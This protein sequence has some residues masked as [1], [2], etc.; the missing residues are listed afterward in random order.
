[1]TVAC[2]GAIGMAYVAPATV[3]HVP[4]EYPT[5]QA[6][7][8]AAV[9][10]DTVLAADGTYAGDGN[11]DIDFNGKA[12]V[13]MSENGPEVT[14]I[15]CEGDSLDP[16]RGFFFGSGEGSAS[17][18]QGFTIK[19]GWESGGGILCFHTSPTIVGNTLMANVTDFRG[20]GILCH[21]GSPA[22][23]GNVLTGNS[24]MALA[25]RGGGIHCSSGASPTIVGNTILANTAVYGGGIGV[26]NASATLL[27]NTILENTAELEGGGIY[28]DGSLMSVTNC[29]LREDS[30]GVGGEISLADRSSLAVRYSDLEGG[31]GAIFM[32]PGC[33]LHWG[34]GNIDEDPM[35]VLAEQGDYR[36]I[37]DSP[38]VDAGHP[39]S[40]DPDSTRSDMGAHYF[41]Q[42]DYMTIYVTPM[43]TEVTPGGTLEVTYTAMN[44][45]GFP[46]SYWALAEAVLPNTHTVT[47][48]GPDRYTLAPHV[49]RQQLIA[50]DVPLTAE[51]GLYLYRARIGVP[52]NTLY[53]EDSFSFEIAPVCDYLIWEADPTPISGQPIMDALSALGRS[54]EFV[55]GPLGNYDLFAYRGLF[56]CLG[57]YSNNAMIMEGSP[58]AAQ[59]EE[60]I[61]AGGSVYL[62]GGDVWYYDPLFMGG[63]DFG[64]SFGII[65]IDDGVGPSIGIVS[66]VENSLMP[67]LAGLTSPYF[68]EN[69]WF[70]W[71]GA[72]PPAEVIFTMLDMPPDI[73]VA[74]PTPSGGHTVGTSFELGGTD[75]VG[76]VVAEFVAFF[77][78]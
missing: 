17:I 46:V 45:W 73:G 24:A 76:E 51:P 70:D 1:M 61:A 11:R 40:L 43:S 27:G 60:Y 3:I 20:G 36:I 5:I 10:G 23:V 13:V 58:A 8:D 7:V 32:P 44:R 72:I 2:F 12:I 71:L 78:D 49:W 47:V 42:N 16:H 62:E 37:W 52:P 14:I 63:H 38:C 64:P 34:V 28:C 53:D 15:D 22:I 59:I 57:V 74:N 67:G 35:F 18:L 65:P 29:I 33:I 9:N 19:N 69:A 39:D 75:F 30:A 26:L 41:D 25:G 54:S 31:A 77:E 55:E 21:N 48:M 68:G 50:Q 4:Q 56:I 6:G 66:G